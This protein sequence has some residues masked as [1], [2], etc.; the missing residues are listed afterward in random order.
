MFKIQDSTRKCV[1]FVEANDSIKDV[2]IAGRNY[3]ILDRNNC[4]PELMKKIGNCLNKNFKDLKQFT[5]A[6][7]INDILFDEVHQVSD[8]ESEI[9]RSRKANIQ[10]FEKTFD[11]KLSPEQQEQ[12]L[13]LFE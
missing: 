7:K 1:S 4:D 11:M 6:L 13:K 9:I 12:L 5:D 2:T 8:P 10:L 3:K